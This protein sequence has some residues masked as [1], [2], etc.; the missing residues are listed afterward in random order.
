MAKS[1]NQTQVG[2]SSPNN[3]CSHREAVG[4]G[5]AYM[6]I[7]KMSLYGLFCA[8]RKHNGVY[9]NVHVVSIFEGSRFDAPTSPFF[10]IQRA[11]VACLRVCVG[12]VSCKSFFLYLLREYY[13]S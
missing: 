5:L 2:S 8:L 4:V 7:N 12:C 10:H 9:R 11:K 13:M 3:E 1:G 6:R